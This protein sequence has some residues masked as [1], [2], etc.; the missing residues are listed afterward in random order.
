MMRATTVLLALAGLL[1]APPARAH[2]FSPGVLTLTETA[3][4]RFAV[5]WTEPVDSSGAPGG[6]RVVYPEHCRSD[7]SVLDCGAKGLEGELLLDGMRGSRMQVVVVVSRLGEPSKELLLTGSE[8][9][10]ELRTAP[11]SAVWLRFGIEHIVLGFDHLAFVIGL[12]LLVSSRKRLLATITAFTIAHSLTLALAALDLVRLPAAAV[13]ATIAASVVLVAREA[14]GSEQTLTRSAPWAVALLF[15]LVHG[16]GFA[17]ALGDLGLPERGLGWALFWFNLGVEVG[18]LAVVAIVLGAAG[19]LRTKL[20]QRRW[21]KLAA[22]YV[23]GSLGM[24]WLIERS[25]AIF[26]GPP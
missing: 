21:P 19:F 24:W 2:D 14:Y 20:E 13:E 25:L 1:L 5:V 7:A 23:L 3:P 17:G 18:Q 11:A 12:M 16:L 15:G 9:R 4:G 8:P 22:C 26:T 10:A 6:V